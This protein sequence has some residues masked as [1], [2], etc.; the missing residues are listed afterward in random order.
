MPESTVKSKPNDATLG[1]EG[2]LFAAADKL[3]GN[4]DTVERI[5]LMPGSEVNPYGGIEI[6]RISH[7][8][9]EQGKSL[10]VS[11]KN[12]RIQKQDERRKRIR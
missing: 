9:V 1:F 7:S 8:M 10:A 5:F 6:S 3:T 12:C 11:S 2:H 4:L